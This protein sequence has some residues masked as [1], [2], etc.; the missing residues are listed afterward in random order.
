LTSNRVD[1][2]DEAFHSRVTVALKYSEHTKETRQSGNCVPD[3]T[4]D[5]NSNIL[6]MECVARAFRDIRN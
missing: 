2:F 6:S 1:V 3:P 5:F 4:P